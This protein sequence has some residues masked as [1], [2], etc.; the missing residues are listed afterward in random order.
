ML[1]KSSQ[2]TAEFGDIWPAKRPSP[3]RGAATESA[4]APR[5][6]QQSRR[7]EEQR[8]PSPVPVRNSHGFSCKQ[9]DYPV[10][11][12]RRGKVVQVHIPPKGGSSIERWSWRSGY[13]FKHEHRMP[14]MR[15][16]PPD[17]FRFAFVRN[18]YTRAVSQ[19]TFCRQGP[20][21]TWNRGFLCHLVARD[22]MRFD[23]WWTLLWASVLRI[24]NGSLPPMHAP[25][26]PGYLDGSFD[27]FGTPSS[28]GDPGYR[29]PP[30]FWCSAD[31]NKPRWWGNCHGP[32]SQ[33]VYQNGRSGAR[34][35]DWVGQLEDIDADFACLRQLLTDTVHGAPA[36]LVWSRGSIITNRSTVRAEET[37]L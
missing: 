20:G 7:L 12:F 11:S 22:R 14:L 30:R 37:V 27:R 33:W 9:S 8:T 1:R 13:N 29:K 24:G 26:R 15:H 35:V 16:D 34:N 4:R 25:K 3:P 23:D 5:T 17:T 21:K 36:T 32:F 28:P 10:K 31:R 2:S 19:Y 18:P 6:R